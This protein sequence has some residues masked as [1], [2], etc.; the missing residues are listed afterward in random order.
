[1]EIQGIYLEI[2]EGSPALGVQV[3]GISRKIEDDSFV[4][5]MSY[6]ISKNFSDKCPYDRVVVQYSE[7]QHMDS[8]RLLIL[9]DGR[10][11][12]FY[13]SELESENPEF[14]SALSDLKSRMEESLK[15]ENE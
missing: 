11:S 14:Y 2:F 10:P 8:S 1:M 12:I 9:K 13:L 4:V 15:N 6:A 7:D 3:D 5:E